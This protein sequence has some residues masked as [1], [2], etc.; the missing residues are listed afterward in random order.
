[1]LPVATTD[2]VEDY[3]VNAADFAFCRMMAVRRYV[4]L[5]GA[6]G[7]WCY[8]FSKTV[9]PVTR[10]T[11]QSSDASA[12]F[13]ELWRGVPVDQVQGH[14]GRARYELEVLALQKRASQAA[15]YSG[16]GFALDRKSGCW[17]CCRLLPSTAAS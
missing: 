11:F 9:G 6:V 13:Q 16:C 4:G 10:R 8:H 5:C 3:A 7:W 15:T 2:L 17:Y 1:M 12:M 14:V